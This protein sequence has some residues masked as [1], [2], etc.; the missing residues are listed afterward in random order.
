METNPNLNP[1]NN[2]EFT[3]QFQ[4]LLS[5]RHMGTKIDTYEQRVA[6]LTQELIQTYKNHPKD[7]LSA[8]Q[9]KVYDTL[10][11]EVQ[12]YSNH[13]VHYAE[14]ARVN[15]TEN[16]NTYD[17]KT[18]WK[19]Y[20]KS[21]KWLED[22]ALKLEN[23]LSEN[24]SSDLEIRIWEKVYA[25]PIQHNANAIRLIIKFEQMYTPEE[26]DKIT[27]LINET[28]PQGASYEEIKDYEANFLKSYREFQ[29][30]FDKK[31]NLWDVI[32]EL[33]AGGV[34]PSPNERVMLE[35]W[36]D[37]EQKIREDM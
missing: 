9:M 1:Q 13:L 22:S 33:L 30:E 3:T 25:T 6:E 11:N 35:K 17:F 21:Y 16:L 10:L 27:N 20:E 5:I 18:L 26:L 15:S 12:V 31:K 2:P 34:H 7:H 14:L 24:A 23:I 37:G 28:I 4:T 8:E 19:E 29:K 36:T 32:M